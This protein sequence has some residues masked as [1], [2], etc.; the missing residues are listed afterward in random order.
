[1]KENQK[2]FNAFKIAHLSDWEATAR[3]ELNGINPWEKLVHQRDGLRIQPYYDRK[4]ANQPHPLLSV[5]E[6]KFLGHRAWYNCPRLVVDEPGKTNQKALEC[7][8][9]GADGIFFELGK[10]I[11]FKVLLKNIEWEYCSLNFL[12]IKN[13]ET[14][15]SALADFV[16]EKKI[17][18]EMFHGAFFCSTSPVSTRF[19]F[20]SMG[21]Q[22]KTSSPVAELIDAFRMMIA[23]LKTNSLAPAGQIA[24]SMT[25]GNDFFLETAKLRSLRMVWNKFQ[26]ATKA[27]T[28][29]PLF[30]HAYLPPWVDTNY[31]PHSN[32]L[33]STTAAMAA[34]LGGCDALTIEPEDS[35]HPM[36]SRVA[37]NVSNILREESYLSKVAD[38]F[39]GSYFME[40]LTRTMSED[41]WK[42][43]QPMVQA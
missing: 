12:A 36:M 4:G 6:N 10:E 7:L 5:S 1:M 34:I 27:K 40:D 41:A 8:Q 17:K 32:M 25:L 24:F 13:Q 42:S 39:A 16:N 23:S 29:A 31:G 28:D 2:K 22:I 14:I 11:D 3:E 26:V 21:F 18:A 33:K 43:I 20:A 30:V 15:A 35:H 9:Q 38:P 37:I 19:P